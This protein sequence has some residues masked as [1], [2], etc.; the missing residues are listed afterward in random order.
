MSAKPL[1]KP[2][3]TTVPPSHIENPF[4]RVSKKELAFAV[5]CKGGKAADV[6]AAMQKVGLT[7]KTAANWFWVFGRVVNGG[8]SKKGA[9]R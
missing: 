5:Y 6:R 3:L 2:K 7:Q 8:K 1:P 4:R 9:Q